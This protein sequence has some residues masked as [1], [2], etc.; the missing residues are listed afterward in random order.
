MTHVCVQEMF[1]KLQGKLCK[2]ICRYLQ[3]ER[4]E[5]A[6]EEQA[7]SAQAEPE[8]SARLEPEVSAQAGQASS[9]KAEEAM[10]AQAL[11]SQAADPS[12]HERPEVRLEL[13]ASQYGF[14]KAQLMLYKLSVSE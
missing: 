12:V 13:Q 9:V 8:L 4:E 3:E 11:G 5:E 7:A 14:K 2:L 10:S 6:E 1:N